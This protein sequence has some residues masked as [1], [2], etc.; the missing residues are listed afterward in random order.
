GAR[1]EVNVALKVGDVTQVVEVKA[2]T[3]LLQTESNTISQVVSNQ[4]IAEMPLNGRDYQQ[5][6]LLTPGVV[7]G[8]NFQ[9]SVGLGGGTS[10]G[11]ASATLAAGQSSYAGHK[12]APGN[13]SRSFG[14]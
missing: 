8:F 13:S 9:T 14:P 2:Q 5:L 1:Y 4:T 10:I 12:Q 3:P 11:S 6:Q 7:S